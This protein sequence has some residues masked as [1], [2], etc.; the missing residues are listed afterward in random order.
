MNLPKLHAARTAPLFRPL[1]LASAL[2]WGA[3]E[4]IALWRSRWGTRL[5]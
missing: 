2:L 3:F 5:R 4:V 1:A